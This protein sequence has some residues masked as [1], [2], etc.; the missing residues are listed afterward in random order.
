MKIFHG[1]RS[2]HIHES[3]HVDH[4]ARIIGDVTVGEG[5]S[6]WC[7]VSI[8]GDF[9]SIRIGKNT[10]IQDNCVLHTPP[11]K[12]PLFIGDCVVVG[13]GAIVH[14]CTVKGPALIGMGSILMDGCVI[15]ED[16]IVGAGSLVTEG[17]VMPSGHM[18]IGRPAKAV[19]PLTDAELGFVREGW[20]DYS[21]F[22]AG[23]RENGCFSGWNP[24]KV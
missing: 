3:V 2:P 17:K 8:R 11:A 19:R 12:N 15:E 6:I 5:S 14:G 21:R 1:G 10:N 22:V 13:H 4:S 16:V 20:K 24:E 18:V 7:N 9:N 23:Y